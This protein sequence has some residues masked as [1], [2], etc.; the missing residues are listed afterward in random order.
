MHDQLADGRLLKLVC[1]L[2]EH[3]RECLAIEVGKSLRNQ[4]VI[5]ITADAHL[6]K[7]AFIRSANGA[8]FTALLFSKRPPIL[9][10]RR[11]HLNR[12]GLGLIC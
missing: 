11:Q 12:P 8:E 3:T 6:W 4:N 7:A 5:L 2:D 9:I 10:L 1:V